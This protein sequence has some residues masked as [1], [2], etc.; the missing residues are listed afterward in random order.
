[1][2]FSSIKRWEPN[3]LKKEALSGMKKIFKSSHLKDA[4]FQN[5]FLAGTEKLIQE[6]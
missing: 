3:L 6:L 1:M 5:H 2:I 4:S